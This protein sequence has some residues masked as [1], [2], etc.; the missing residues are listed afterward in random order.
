MRAIGPQDRRAGA[1]GS[2]TQITLNIHTR[3]LANP[4]TI[5]TQ[6]MLSQDGCFQN[7]VEIVITKT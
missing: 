6:E 5:H 4:L 7:T 3:F 1:A 2:L